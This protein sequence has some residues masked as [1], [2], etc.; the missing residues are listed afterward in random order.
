MVVIIIVSCGVRISFRSFDGR[1]LLPGAGIGFTLSGAG[2]S[3]PA[4]NFDGGWMTAFQ[5]DVFIVVIDRLRF[6]RRGVFAFRWRKGREKDDVE[7]LGHA[8]MEHLAA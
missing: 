1:F 2:D 8:T 6:G 3:T 7:R 5:L 4:A